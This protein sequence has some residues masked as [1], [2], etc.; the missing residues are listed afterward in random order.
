M[1]FKTHSPWFSAYYRHVRKAEATGEREVTFTCDGPG[2][3]ELPLILGQLTILPKHWWAGTVKTGQ[4]RNVADTTLE[5]PLG[6]GPYRIGTFEAGQSIVYERV[7]D[8]W[9]AILMSGSAT[10]TSTP[11][12]ST[13]SAT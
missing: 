2:N 5:P 9:A 6:S 3:R 1:K 4:P 12:A 8:Y 11:C 7:A 10:T 13:I